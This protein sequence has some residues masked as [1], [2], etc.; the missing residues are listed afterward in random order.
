MPTP[1]SA[2]IDFLVRSWGTEGDGVWEMELK[3][4]TPCM[5][6]TLFLLFLGPVPTEL[7]QLDNL[8]ELWV[9][10]NGFTGTIPTQFGTL[11][12]L[13][14]LR[15][16][17]CNQEG[18]IPTELF[19]LT[20]LARLDLHE[21]QLSGTLSPLIANLVHLEQLRV[22]RNKLTGTIPPEL[23]NLSE[24]RLAWLHLNEMTGSM[25]IDICDN[26]GTGEGYLEFL[27]TDCNPED[28][29][30]IECLC[31]SACCDRTTQICLTR[32]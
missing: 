1:E 6:C 28:N 4:K 32:T 29:P 5:V 10:E 7:G 25:P 27:Q 18:T 12:R 2:T 17:G 13:S 16:S 9:H 21:Q 14:D 24:L 19:E 22:S 15:I 30:P 3:A 31:C 20:R 23:A 11:S 26:V 8:V